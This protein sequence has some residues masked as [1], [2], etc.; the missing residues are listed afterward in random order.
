MINNNQS[1]QDEK[2]SNELFPF[3]RFSFV[4]VMR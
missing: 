2:L 4:I 3:D 1:E